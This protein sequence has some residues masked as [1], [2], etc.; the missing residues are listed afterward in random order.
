MNLG[1]T[2]LDVS[3]VISA[4]AQFG[5]SV[6]A[7]PQ[8]TL[9]AL[10][11]TTLDVTLTAAVGGEVNGTVDVLTNDPATPS[12]SIAI[13]GDVTAPVLTASPGALNFGNMVIGWT[14]PT[15][16][17]TLDNTGVGELTITAI[18]F[19]VGSSPLVRLA[20]VP[21]LPIK[22]SPDEEPVVISVYVEAQQL[23]A[24]PAVLLLTSDSVL[25]DIIRVDISG[26]V[27][28][29]EEG[30]PIANGVPSCSSGS[31]QVGDCYEGYHN[32]DQGPGNG[33]E[34]QE[35]VVGNIVGDIGQACPGLNLGGHSDDD[36]DFFRSGTLH[37]EDDVD[38]YYYEANDDTQFLDDDYGARVTLEGA[39]AG[40]IICANFQ[41]EGS[42]CG[43]L[44][45][46]CSP[47]RVNGH[48]QSGV[49]GS[50]NNSEDATVWVMWAP[51]AAPMCGSY[52]VRFATDDNM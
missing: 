42:G 18:A 51:G 15:Q 28:T 38:M 8:P 43:G 37:S 4:G 11:Q 41:Q 26:N 40:M 17:L 48:G 1:G 25:D 22:L 10:Q 5:L 52:T 9:G 50:S 47:T 33:C 46:N 7:A 12:V 45:T 32:A 44:P 30:C 49:F 3:A 6:G 20:N 21:D 35:D 13:E 27:V 14:A 31:C 23:G 2:P 34:C 24:T 39:P 36:G 16:T 29:C 19:D